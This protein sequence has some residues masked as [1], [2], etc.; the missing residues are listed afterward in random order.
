MVQPPGCA[1]PGTEYLV[2]KLK[3][4]L[5]GLKQSPRAWYSCIDLDLRNKGMIRT[6]ADS[7]VYLFRD[8]S[9][10]IILALYIDDLEYIHGLKQALQIEYKMTDLGLLRKFLGVQFHQTE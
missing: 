3:Q 2:C 5:Y 7:N 1:A 10:I 9:S 8:Q 4:S 6:Q